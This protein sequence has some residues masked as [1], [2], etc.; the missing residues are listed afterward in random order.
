MIIS[1]S[2]PSPSPDLCRAVSRGS[3]VSFV[4]A[5]WRLLAQPLDFYHQNISPIV[6]RRK[7]V[8][9][10]SN[11]PSKLPPVSLAAW[12]TRDI[13]KHGR[14][15]RTSHTGQHGCSEIVMKWRPPLPGFVMTALPYWIPDAQRKSQHGHKRVY[16]VANAVVFELLQGLDLCQSP[17]PLFIDCMAQYGMGSVAFMAEL[18]LIGLILTCMVPH[19]AYLQIPR[20]GFLASICDLIMSRSRQNSPL[21]IAL[22][23]E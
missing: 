16:A 1:V 8:E 15:W 19:V 10:L 17:A 6:S 2:P 20:L 11:R 13:T 18:L 22:L 21:Y 9:K 5:P 7:P 4:L 12:L 14:Q 3:A 23:L